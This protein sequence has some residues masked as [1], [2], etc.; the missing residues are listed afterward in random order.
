VVEFGLAINTNISGP[1]EFGLIKY[2]AWVQ[3]RFS[4]VTQPFGCLAVCV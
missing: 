2:M 3:F 4:S 1:V